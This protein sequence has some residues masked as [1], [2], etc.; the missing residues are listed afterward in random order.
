V[1]RILTVI[2]LAAALLLVPAPSPAGSDAAAWEQWFVYELNRARWNPGGYAA[3][4]GVAF[5]APIGA[6]P[7]LAVNSQLTASA[8]S[9]AH[10]MAT[11]DY[12]SH[13][14]PVTGA[15]PNRIVRDHGFSL[16]SWAANAANHVESIWMGAGAAWPTPAA[17]LAS[18][19]HRA[20]LL[21]SSE[22][23]WFE[24][25][26]EVGIGR[27]AASGERRA[28]VH[29]ARADASRVFVTGVAFHDANGNGKMDLGEGLPGVLVSVGG[30]TVP[31]NPGGGY[32][33]AVSPGRMT[34]AASGGGFS[35]T[36]TA[37]FRVGDHNVGVDFVSGRRMAEVRAFELCAG[38]RPTI[39]GTAG[40]DVI[41]GTPGNDVI[42]G[43]DG[44]DIIFGLAGD[45]LICGGRGDDTIYGGRGDDVIYGGPGDD[46]LYGGRGSDRLRGGPGIDHLDGG[47]GDRNRCL[48]GVTLVRCSLPS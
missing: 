25:A 29:L 32:T 48:G 2:A 34:A 43:L 27:H 10:E 38:R 11:F 1:A 39:M 6:L 19:A 4:H 45:D 23:W 13:R 31:T 22:N 42:A 9:R 21:A 17:F 7:P 16:P 40:D 24:S 47:A 15:W 5:P 20:V 28:A 37:S 8:S 30:V 18:G 46:R 35:G 44:D 12:F 33:V 26:N 41:V 36:S 3:E 14:S